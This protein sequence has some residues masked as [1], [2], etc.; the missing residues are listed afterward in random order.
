[1]VHDLRY[2]LRTFLKTPGFTTIAVVTL[3]VGIGANTAIFSVVHAVLLR[4]LPFKAPDTIVQV[5]TATKDEPRSGHS[6]ADYLDLQRDNQSLSAIAGY[7]NALFTLTV[8]QRDPEQ[9]EGVYVTSDF[10]DVLGVPAVLGR[11]F[12][13]VQD[14]PGVEP[15]IV[16]SRRVWEQL[17]AASPNAI[18][19]RIKVNGEWHTV[20]GVMPAR[21]EWPS[22]ARVW[23]LSAKDV[24][25]SPLDISG[26]E[27]DRDVRYFEAI[28]RL[29][30]GITL[31]QAADDLKRVSVAIQQR[32]P[33]T[34]AGRDIKLGPIHE[35]VVGEVRPA[36]L[37]LQA[38]VAL[39][40]AIACANVSSLLIARAMGRTREIAVRAALG[41]KR[42]RLARQL[43][44]ESLV[45]G[46][47][48]GIS[49]LLLASWL[50]GLLLRIVPEGVPRIEEITID[51]VVAGITLATAIGTGMLFGVLPAVQASRAYA[52]SALKDSGERTSGVRARGRAVLVVAE[53]ALTVVLL[54][55]AALLAN[56]FVRL[57]RVDSGWRPD[58]VSVMSLAI[59]QPRYPT[60]ASQTELYR[61][62]IEGLSDRPEVQAVGVGF[63]GPLRGSNASGAFLVE[64]R[65]SASRADRPFANIG[66]VSGGY[67]AA[68]GI[69]ILAGRTFTEADRDDAPPVAIVSVALGRRYWRGENPIG[70]R[71]R[72]DD[73][74]PWMTIVGVAGDVRQLGLDR[75]PPPILYLPYQVFAL[76]F[77][78]LAVRSSAPH[79]AVASLLRAQVRAVDPEMPRGETATLHTILDRSVD[80]PRFRTLLLSAFALTALLLA[81][82]GVYGLISYSVTQRTREIG[83][84]IAL[85]ARPGQIVG[86]MLREG[87]R[88][89]LG[90]LALGLA[91]AFV[92]ARA[93]SRFLFGIGAGDPLTFA[94]VSLL[95]FAVAI[96]ACYLPA[97]RAMRV[98]PM[99]ALRSE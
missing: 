29:K 52:A 22:A 83:I 96:V 41:A 33:A 91:G 65:P 47:T 81:A 63:P 95:L 7:R 8:D 13:R 71:L 85:G 25:P 45:L 57:Q 74:E 87:L 62:L 93:I 21:A 72:F 51:W 78:N 31:E 18:D 5:W 3:A 70:K 38:A 68:M 94:G 35:R 89:A 14:A 76:P 58:Q 26:S 16:L 46:V 55:G 30:P 60:A 80:E 40:L 77:T 86:P 27:V 49:G 36:L 17:F 59:P 84:R 82:V 42:G 75:P 34:A 44:T 98:D 66:S 28:A 64:G 97:R 19:G 39:V 23:V 67:F 48:G 15:R 10:F 92:A 79:A 69:P 37:V 4:P 32:H 61:R 2:A 12:T 90:G 43:L 99:V 88:L 54:T 50:I 6:A 53:I 1:M 73:D 56:S 11:T 9:L 20:I 24:P